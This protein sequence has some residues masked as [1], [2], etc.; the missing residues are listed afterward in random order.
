MVKEMT[1]IV[2]PNGCLLR[3]EQNGEEITVTGNICKRGET[4]GKTELTNP[5][6]TIC[7]TV[8]TVFSDIEVVPVRVSAEIPKG[9]IFPVMEEINK[10]RLS[11][12]LGIGEKVIENVLGLNADVI[13]TSNILKEEV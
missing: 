5:M 10:V 4:F 1:C 2:C 7:S 8:R 9:M 11:E 12:R 3:V 13:L 6:R